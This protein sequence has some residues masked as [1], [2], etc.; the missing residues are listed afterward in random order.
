MAQK[1]IITLVD[2]IDQSDATQTV[3]FGI[4]GSHYE[5]DLNDRNADALREALSNYVAHARKGA[6]A[7][8]HGRRGPGATPASGQ[9][10]RDWAKTA[11]LN[12]P[13][14]G[15]VPADIKRAYDAVH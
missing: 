4:D 5:I 8:R 2:D 3:L 1:V 14:R 9:E 15:R 12:V 10:I 7:S 6:R 13:D 11:G